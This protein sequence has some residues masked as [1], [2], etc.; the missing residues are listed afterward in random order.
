VESSTLETLCAA[1]EAVTRLVEECSKPGQ[2]NKGNPR[3]VAQV[4]RT[5]KWHLNAIA[6]LRKLLDAPGSAKV[7]GQVRKRGA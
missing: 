1:E 6:A 5:G 2:L 4:S 7:D 3:A